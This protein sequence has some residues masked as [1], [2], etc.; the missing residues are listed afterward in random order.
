[1]TILYFPRPSRVIASIRSRLRPLDISREIL[2]DVLG[3]YDFDMVGK[4]YNL[5]LS[6]RTGN[7]VIPVTG[8]KVVLKRYRDHLQ[9]DGIQ[10]IH[11]ILARLFELSFP[12]PKLIPASSGED[13]ISAQSGRYAVF[14]FVNGRNHSLDYIF[15]SDR[16][17][18]IHA[19]GK[20]LATYHKILNG[21][22]PKGT[23]HLG[24]LSYTGGWQRDSIWF[25]N[26][27]RELI[28]KSSAISNNEEKTIAD[29]LIEHSEK[30]LDDF[31]RL[32]EKLQNAHLLRTIVHGDFGLHNL[33]FKKDGKI[34]LTDYETTRLEWRLSDLVI[35]LSRSRSPETMVH[36]ETIRQFLLGYQD[37]YPIP[38]QEWQYLPDV[39]Q[40]I[41]LR[42][43]FI[44]WNLYFER[45]GR[46]LSSALD[47]YRQTVWVQK[48]SDTLLKLRDL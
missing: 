41:K 32:D 14:E 28:E 46:N 24:F 30:I 33:I 43:I 15:S 21:F 12:A 20:I 22:Q 39:W 13:F 8:G 3:H 26:K 2:Q 36:F 38:A 44:S 16:Y 5:A 17:K 4:P 9:S 1:M 10:Y 18:L 25:T 23:H 19:S 37:V 45:G 47:A 7:V 31:K 48:N 6:R 35:T 34:I 11:S 40:F 42:S 29:F 27:A